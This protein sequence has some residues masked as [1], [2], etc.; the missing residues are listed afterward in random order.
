MVIVT[1]DDCNV[2]LSNTRMSGNVPGCPGPLTLAPSP[3]Y[4]PYSNPGHL[5]Q[6]SLED[7]YI[8]ILYCSAHS[9][10]TVYMCAV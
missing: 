2:V 3:C 9:G 7:I 10:C 5:R 6:R 1:V 4:W 8:I